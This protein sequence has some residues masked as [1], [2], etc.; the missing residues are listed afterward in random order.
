MRCAASFRARSSAR[1]R[2]LGRRRRHAPIC[3]DE[4][5]TRARTRGSARPLPRG[6]GRPE[7]GETRVSPPTC[8]RGS[9]KGRA[10]GDCD[11]RRRARPGDRGPLDGAARSAAGGGAAT[12]KPERRSDGCG[13]RGGGTPRPRGP[14]SGRTH[15]DAAHT[16]LVVSVRVFRF[17]PGPDRLGSSAPPPGAACGRHP[18][19]TRPE[20]HTGAWR[21]LGH[22]RARG[23]ARPS[24]SPV[25]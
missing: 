22:L 14:L 7:P 4:T 23:A 1:T 16:R 2:S 15:A 18:R 9:V 3:R 6:V 8:R 17:L 13:G 19:V 10:R 11:P 20:A 12:E 25:R 24:H 21:A 5:G